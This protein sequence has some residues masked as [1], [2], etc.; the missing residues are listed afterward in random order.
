MTYKKFVT[1]V[2]KLEKQSKILDNLYKNKVNLIDFS[3]QY[4]SIIS[5]LLIEIYGEEGY[6]W[7]SWFCYELEFGKKVS[8]ENPRAW[9]KEGIPICYDLYT[10]WE[11][12]ESNR[13]K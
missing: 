7:F 2:N 4:D 8:I 5:D 13:K 10:L 3:D 1:I 9:D 12:L 6:N 11:Y